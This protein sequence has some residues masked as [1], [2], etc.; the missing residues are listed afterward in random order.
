[1]AQWHSTRILLLA[2]WHLV[3]P[4]WPTWSSTHEPH[5]KCG[6]KTM[7]LA[8]HPRSTFDIPH[9]VFRADCF[10]HLPRCS[11]VLEYLPTFTHL[12]WPSFVGKYSSTMEHLG[13]ECLHC[14][15]SCMNVCDMA[16]STRSLYSV[17]PGLHLDRH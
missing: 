7:N 3:L 4:S 10:L 13:Y 2:L 15:Y 1:M 17:A 14:F 6:T 9:L 8:L 11:M 5:K 16:A 12:T